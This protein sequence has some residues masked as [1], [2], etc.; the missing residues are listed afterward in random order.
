[1]SL[2]AEGADSGDAPEEETEDVSQVSKDQRV[3]PPCSGIL[4]GAGPAFLALS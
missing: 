4:T 1:M 3:P 2:D